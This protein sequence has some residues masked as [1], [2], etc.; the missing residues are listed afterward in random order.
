[1]IIKTIWI[2]HHCHEDDHF[3]L[4]AQIDESI[5]LAKLQKHCI[6]NNYDS[7]LLKNCLVIKQGSHIINILKNGFCSLNRFPDIKTGN[8]V[9]SQLQKWK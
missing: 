3:T 1:M 9:I 7:I 5:D 6:Q 4:S 8:S 2:E